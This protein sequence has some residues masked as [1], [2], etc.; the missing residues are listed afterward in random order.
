MVGDCR[1]GKL[2]MFSPQVVQMVGDGR[3]GKFQMFRLNL[4]RGSVI[5]G[6]VNYKCSASRRTDGW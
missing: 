6:L 3:V 2:Q 5:A 1:V 4:Y